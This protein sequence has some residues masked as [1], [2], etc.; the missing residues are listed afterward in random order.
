LK[1]T[2]TYSDCSCRYFARSGAGNTEKTLEAIAQR[3]NELGIKKIIIPTYSGKSALAAAKIIPPAKIVAVTT[4]AGFEKSNVQAMKDTIRQKL[5]SLGIPV[6][7]CTHAFGGV[8][9]SVRKKLNSYQIDEIIAYTL[10]IFGQGTKVAIEAA[11]MAADAGHVRTNEDIISTGG[12]GSGLDT[13]LVLRPV[14]ASSF[15]DMK[16]REF[17]CKPSDF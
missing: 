17:I 3:A 2:N 14:N 16:V 8:G 7:T 12:S 1:K 10:R 9:R 6:L 11:L 4:A 13:A 15:L 5:M